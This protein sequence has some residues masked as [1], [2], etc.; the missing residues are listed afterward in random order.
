MA[1]TIVVRSLP[2]ERFAQEIVTGNHTLV[3]DEPESVGG[4]DLG[5]GPYDY[6]L[7]ALGT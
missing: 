5:P 3:A 2:G 1:A 7:A 4:S 6:L